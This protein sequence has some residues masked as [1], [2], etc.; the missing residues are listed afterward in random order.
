M[1][2]PQRKC[3]HPSCRNFI[4]FT[5]T[6]CEKHEPN[7]EYNQAR[8]RY[9]NTYIKF[10]K[11]RAWLKLRRIALM[12]DDFMCKTCERN[13]IIKEAQLVHHLIEVKTDWDKRLELENLESICE[14]CHQKIHKR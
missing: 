14:S 11:T 7:K 4:A 1:A 10:Y 6:Y 8:R 5:R 2:A 9:D 3:F 13:G 12:R